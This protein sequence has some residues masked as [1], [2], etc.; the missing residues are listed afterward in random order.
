MHS[1]LIYKDN[2][3]IK[4]YPLAAGKT[5]S[6]GRHHFND[7]HLPDPSCKVSRFHTALFCDADGI[8]FSQDLGSRNNTYVNGERRDYGILIDGDKIAIGDYTLVLQKQI[9]K[10]RKSEFTL[11][12]DGVDSD[13]TK[14]IFSPKYFQW[15]EVRQLKDDSEGLLLLYQLSRLAN[16]GLDIE[17]S[18]Q[19]I[20]EEL[21]KALHP[22]RIFIA[23][24]ER[25]GTG[26]TCL[27][28][29]PLDEGNIKVSRTML[30]Y[31]LQEK[32]I[33]ITD[34]ALVDERFKRYGAT[35]RSILKLQ[36][37]SAICVPLQWDGE[38]R[39]ILYLDS[40]RGKG[41]FK[42]RD[43][44]LIN[45]IG[46]D[47]ST[48]MERGQKYRAVNDE[49]TCL[50]RRLEMENTIIGISPKIKEVLKTVERLADADVTVLITGETGTGKDLF[51]EAIHRNSKR[52]E[53]PFIAVN[54]AAIPDNLMESEMF[55]VIANYP[56]LHN[57]EALKGKF[58]LANGGTIFLNEIG[59]LPQRLQAKLLEAL[60]TKK[61]WPLGANRPLSVDIRII[62]ATNKNLEAEI[63]EGN[64]RQDLYERLNMFPLYLPPLRERKEDIPLLGGYFIYRSRQKYGKKIDRLSSSCIE[65]LSTYEWPRNIRELK[66][67][68]ER[69]IILTDR[70]VITP[71]LFVIKDKVK[72]RPKSLADIE[73]EHI[74]K[75]LEYTGGNK[76]KAFRILG[77]S[78]QTLYNKIEE[79]KLPDLKG[80]DTV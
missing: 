70:S 63:T 66:N 33:L 32:Q 24:L 41:L 26:L 54:C 37:K 60:E 14:T 52:K 42:E 80:E 67:A 65:L 2:N 20:I 4:T 30:Q 71:D 76:E 16:S 29:S 55:G 34:N 64:F 28:R 10:A 6:T 49:K 79:Y 39:G 13:G 48:F 68:I 27:A 22:D 57:K 59:E 40:S 31:L 47:L 46:N 69:A 23:L 58:E 9:E 74:R 35:A 21:S 51:V 61:I 19:L 7:I 78:K 43:L 1:I 45:L 8:Y 38:T 72:E 12:D 50:E 25:E 18:L 3:L 36:I 62:A 73:K 15:E 44:R 5:V 11:V 77:I 56:G 75:V 17:E 53:R